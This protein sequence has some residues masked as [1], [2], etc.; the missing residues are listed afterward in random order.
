MF[1]LYPLNNL[2]NKIEGH[3]YFGNNK[4]LLQI[5]K[6]ELDW[7][8]KFSEKN[9]LIHKLNK[10][11]DEIVILLEKPIIELSEEIKSNSKLLN[12][13][14]GYEIEKRIEY[15]LEDVNILSINHFIDLKVIQAL[16]LKMV[17]KP[18][19][20]INTHT[21]NVTKHQYAILRVLW[22]DNN[23][24]KIRKYSTSLGNLDTFGSIENIN[25]NII[26]EEK[27]KLELKLQEL[28]AEEY[29]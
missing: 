7:K 9:P 14:K 23:L 26:K 27:K 10:L 28:Y 15:T 3:S 18:E 6:K 5:L 1:F 24:K 4:R 16:K 12:K 2:A 17:I 20:L 22:L 8:D 29:P 19:F 21:H 13:L 11:V 25:P